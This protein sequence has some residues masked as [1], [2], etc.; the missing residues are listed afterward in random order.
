MADKGSA[1]LLDDFLGMDQHWFCI[2][3][4]TREGYD[5]GESGGHG[6]TT[7]C[8]TGD[9]VIAA[10]FTMDSHSTNPLALSKF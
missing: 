9:L 3:Q 6:E 8:Q 4:G 1:S 5:V 7:T 10:L 2:A